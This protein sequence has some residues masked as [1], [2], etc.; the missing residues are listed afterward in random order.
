MIHQFGLNHESP[1]PTLRILQFGEY[2]YLLKKRKTRRGESL[3][4]HPEPT[5]R[6]ETKEYKQKKHYEKHHKPKNPNHPAENHANRQTFKYKSDDLSKEG[7]E[8]FVNDFLKGK[9]RNYHRADHI[10]QYNDKLTLRHLNSYNYQSF[11]DESEEAEKV[12]VIWVCSKADHE[13]KH[14]RKQLVHLSKHVSFRDSVN[15][16]MI[17][18]NYND[19]PEYLKSRDHIGKLYVY[20]KETDIHKPIK[21]YPFINLKQL[22]FDFKTIADMINEMGYLINEEL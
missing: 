18:M 3:P 10:P 12:A 13:H 6:N 16:G 17:D 1:L 9:H 4:K 7:I 22:F 19:L 14:R 5:S 15:F 2:E 11:L 21:V 8:K 20:F